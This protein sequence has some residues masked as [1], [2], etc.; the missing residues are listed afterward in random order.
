[1]SQI[2][3]FFDGLHGVI[4]PFGGTVAPAGFLM[5]DGSAVSRTTYATLF[6]TIG[7]AFG[8]GDGSTT[9]NL[10]DTRGYFMRGTDNGAGVDIG[11]S[12]GS[13]QQDAMQGH[14]HSA[15]YNSAKNYTTGAVSGDYLG[16]AVTNFVDA[17][18]APTSDGS[19]GTPRT[20]AETRPKNL[21]VNYIIKT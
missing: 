9:F 17:V 15:G 19:N 4:F 2:S 6:A 3:S 10:P 16:V 1:V 18:L 5:C 14:H 12:H 7:T 8:S 21:A 11:R 20:A 13:K